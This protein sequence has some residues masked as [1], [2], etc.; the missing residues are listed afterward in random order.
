MWTAAGHLVS[1]KPLLLHAHDTVLR[2]EHV[3]KVFEVHVLLR[4]R[5][6]AVW[7]QSKRASGKTGGGVRPSYVPPGLWPLCRN[8]SV[9][10]DSET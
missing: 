5:A 8:G 2:F 3:M 7:W 6:P 1:M 4:T 9:S 10:L